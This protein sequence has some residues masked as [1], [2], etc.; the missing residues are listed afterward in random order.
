MKVTN[1]AGT[2]FE[3]AV[4]RTVRVLAHWEIA[5]MLDVVDLPSR[6]VA[7]EVTNTVTNT[8]DRPWTKDKGL[9]SIWILGMYNPS[10]DM[11]VLV[12]FDRGAS[13]D[14][15]NDRYFGKVPADRLLVSD[16]HLV[17]RCDGKLRSK[18]GLGPERAKN[19]LGSYSA[20]EGL[21]TLVQ[22]DKPKSTTDYVNSMWDEQKNPYKGDA[23]NSYNDGPTEPG[24]PSLGGFYELE[25]SS[26]ALA[27]APGK[28]A[29]HVQRT[30]HFVADASARGRLAQI[31]RKVLGVSLP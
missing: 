27:L 17:F 7:F 12:P 18:I 19:V 30:F 11:S 9:L 26:P 8:G 10:D 29:K 28:S 15:V 25:T 13:G 24:K 5:K 6:Y 31:A 22:Y 1:Y 3:L 23:V 16:D 21:L 4:E 20:S 2:T 14:I